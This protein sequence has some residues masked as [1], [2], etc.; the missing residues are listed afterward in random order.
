M[1]SGAAEAVGEVRNE[2]GA[3]RGGAREQ[4]E[5][6]RG[7]A[8]SFTYNEVRSFVGEACSKLHQASMLALDVAGFMD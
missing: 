3:V 4:D 6:L 8:H 1:V 5:G 2:Y 7:I